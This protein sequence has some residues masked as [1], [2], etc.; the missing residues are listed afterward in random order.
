[1]HGAAALVSVGTAGALAPDLCAGDMLL[2]KS[3]VS[4]A[5][6]TPVTS[7]WREHLQTVLASAGVP[8]CDRPLLQARELIHTVADKR[9]LYAD[10]GCVAVDMESGLLAKQAALAGIPYIVARVVVD[11]ADRTVPRSAGAV[12][13]RDGNLKPGALLL[14]LAKNPGDAA[15]FL[16]LARD[17]RQAAA[18]LRALGI[19]GTV[20]LL[21]GADRDALAVLNR[22]REIS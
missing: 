8:A 3:I 4:T 7:E 11:P 15:R 9:R 13:G 14:A 17:F 21:P 22:Q 5:G 6:S 12:T 2:P 1:M 10:T 19:F 20:A 16:R 18:T